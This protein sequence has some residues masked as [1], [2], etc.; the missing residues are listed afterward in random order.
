[1]VYEFYEVLLNSVYQNFVEN[2]WIY[3]HQWYWPLFSFF[4]CCF[5]LVFISEWW[6]PRRMSLEVFFEIFW[7]SCRRIVI[8]SSLNAACTFESTQFTYC[9]GLTVKDFEHN[10]SGMRN[11]SKCTTIWTFF[12][13]TFHWDWNENWPFPVLWPLLSFPTLLAYWVQHFHSTITLGFEIAHLEF[14]HLY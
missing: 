4:V 7:K 8:S 2:F 5:C 6:W 10:L 11:E 14:H 1:M 9:R 13:I 12:D 3:V